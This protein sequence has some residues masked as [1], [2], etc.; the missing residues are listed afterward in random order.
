MSDHNSMGDRSGMARLNTSGTKI[1]EWWV[2]NIVTIW[3]RL[4]THGCAQRRSLDRPLL[5]RHNSAGDNDGLP[6]RRLGASSARHYRPPYYIADRGHSAG[7]SRMEFTYK[8]K[9]ES[10]E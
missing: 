4:S 5:F 2:R 3:V 9:Y 8:L 6:T 1:H 10:Y 7:Q